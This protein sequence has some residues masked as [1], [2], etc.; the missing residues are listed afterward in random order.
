MGIFSWMGKRREWLV[1]LQAFLFSKVGVDMEELDVRAEELCK[2]HKKKDLARKLALVG[3]A[4]EA[5]A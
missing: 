5:E 4:V 3:W 2:K 1:L